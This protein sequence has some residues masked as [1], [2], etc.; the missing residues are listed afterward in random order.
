MCLKVISSSA[1]SSNCPSPVEFIMRIV[2]G[3]RQSEQLVSQL[4][5]FAE[6]QVYQQP[7]AKW[8]S[9]ETRALPWPRAKTM[10]SV[11]S[12]ITSSTA[13]RCRCTNTHTLTLHF[14][15][16]SRNIDSEVNLES[17][18]LHCSGLSDTSCEL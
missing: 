9:L 12:K 17:Q 13:V 18:R 8:V 4:S 7:S 11:S 3:Y 10:P 2:G 16:L 15:S 5:L 14:Y 1:S 6:C